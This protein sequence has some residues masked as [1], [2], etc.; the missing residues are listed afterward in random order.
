M[1]QKLN[2]KKYG[3]EFISI[4]IAVI[5][6]F[7]LNNWNDNRRDNQAAAKILTEISNGFQKDLEDIK[8]N[9][10][11]HQEGM[12][13]CN[14]WRKVINNQ[15][16][17]NDS[18]N[19]YYLAL[20]R[21]FFTIQNNSGYETLKSRGLELIK[22][23]SLRFDIISLYEYDYEALKIM[24]ESYHE[25]QFQENYFKDFNKSIAPNFEFDDLGNISKIN[26]PL[27][28]S[29]QDQKIILSYLWK[30]QINR[31]FILRYYL[32]M[33]EKIQDLRERIEKEI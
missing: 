21:D 20:T 16:F 24:E 1:D 5:S 18:L 14:F 9:I 10:A 11:G 28:I 17:S 19:Q 4:F 29:P 22:N 25:M 3:I 33:E 8:I 31:I 27:E 15:E 2:W 6:A 23:D 32:G 7:A 26:L 13:A 30:I 12:A